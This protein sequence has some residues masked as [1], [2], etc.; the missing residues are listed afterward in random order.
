MKL[1]SGFIV[2]FGFILIFGGVGN[3][4][5]SHDVA[6]MLIGLLISVM[7]GVTMFAGFLMGGHK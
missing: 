4:E 6:G 7:G 2:T 5:A 1:L 3:I